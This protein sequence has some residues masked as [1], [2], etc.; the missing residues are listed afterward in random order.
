MKLLLIYLIMAICLSPIN[1][2]RP[3][4]Q[5]NK[6]RIDVPC[7]KCMNCLENRRSEWSFR[8]RQELKG[9]SSAY[10][11]T[12]TYDDL[13]IPLM[14]LGDIYRQYEMDFKFMK[15]TEPV[16]SL[17][18]KDVQD[19]LKRLRKKHAKVSKIPIRYYAVGE[20]GTNSSRPHYHLCLF[21]LDYSCTDKVAQ[22]PH[23]GYW[24]NTITDVWNM[25]IAHVGNLN[26]ASIHYV[27]GYLISN[28]SE[29]E[30]ANKV[31]SSMSLKPA[32]GMRYVQ[33]NIKHH[34]DNAKFYVNGTKPGKKQRLP[35]YYRDKMF[36][37]DEVEMYSDKLQFEFDERT[38]KRQK[39]LFKKGINPFLYETTLT[40]NKRRRINKN[41][42]KVKL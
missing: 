18:K 19:F 33:K 14:Y 15:G 9:S 23:S 28:Q 10:F 3:N 11:L 42:K 2:V 29:P 35:R 6:D 39:K 32:I 40:E 22:I 17:Y 38:D 8:L 26:D 5:G 36:S 12:L 27:C 20:Y 41:S 31:F 24:D 4:G 1:I 37:K 13:H 21:N 34:R 30:G 25:G 7:G 16:P